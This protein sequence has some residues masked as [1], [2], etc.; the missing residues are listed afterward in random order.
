MADFRQAFSED[1]AAYLGGF[2]RRFG[3]WIAR[4]ASA[5]F[6]RFYPDY[7]HEGLRVWDT[8]VFATLALSALLGT[9]RRNASIWVFVLAIVVGCTF[10]LHTPF[11][12]KVT[13]IYPFLL[14][15]PYGLARVARLAVG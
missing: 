7:P 1:P 12:P 9:D 14:L 11:T 8:F 13:L 5:D 3:G 2:V 6:V 15:A 10:P 4:P